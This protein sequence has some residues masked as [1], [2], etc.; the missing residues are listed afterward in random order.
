MLGSRRF[1]LKQFI[2]TWVLTL[3]HTGM[4]QGMAVENCVCITR[5]AVM[6]EKPARLV[7]ETY[8]ALAA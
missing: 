2:V 7:T 6:K 1:G 5:G 8:M 4:K 3:C